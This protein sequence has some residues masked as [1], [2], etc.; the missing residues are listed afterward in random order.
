MQLRDIQFWWNGKEIEGH[1][2]LSTWSTNGARDTAKSERFTLGLRL[3][4]FVAYKEVVRCEADFYE[5]FRHDFSV[6]NTYL[7]L[8]C[9]R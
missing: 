5:M 3:I 7:C 2:G 6:A 9:M 4:F 8:L 1:R